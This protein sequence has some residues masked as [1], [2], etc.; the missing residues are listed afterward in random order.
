[1]KLKYIS[2][3]ILPS[4]FAN[5]VH[6]MKM[7]S[8][9]SRFSDVELF[10]IEGEDSTDIYKAYSV[11]RN[12]STRKFKKG[13]GRIASILYIFN[14][15][16]SVKREPDTL[17]YGRH[18]LSLLLLSLK[19]MPF[20]YEAHSLPSG[21]WG[22]ITERL[23]FSLPNFKKLVVISEAL[24]KDYL[25]EVSTLSS[26]DILIAH[27]GADAPPDLK[28][29]ES[30]SDKLKVGYI[31]QLYK[32]RGVELI[33]ELASL[34]SNIDFVIVGGMDNDISYWKAQTLNLCNIEFKGHMSHKELSHYY[35]KIDVLIA[36]YQSGPNQFIGNADTSRWMSPMKIFE[37]MS[38]KKPIV[39]S[40]IPVLRETLNE[41]N[42]CLV[43]S[44]NVEEWVSAIKLLENDICFSEYIATNAYQDFIGKYTWEK[45]AKYILDK[46]FV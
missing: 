9:F 16:T 39:C 14:I 23:L 45:R 18:L 40:D 21:F 17:I 1:M 44:D 22:A 12:F 29:I 36:P 7:C 6:V 13:T 4:R 3:S 38:Y 24:K 8:A 28:V 20:A 37:Y 11:E 42:S 33:V 15:F 34:M 19:G 5:S 26:Q 43:A 2:T 10:A 31:G 25:L 30:N 41:T 35:S 46:V 32:G 27:D